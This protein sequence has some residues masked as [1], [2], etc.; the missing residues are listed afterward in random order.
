MHSHLGMY[1]IHL[2]VMKRLVYLL[3]GICALMVGIGCSDDE[4]SN[5][6]NAVI[7]GVDLEGT[8]SHEVTIYDNIDNGQ[9]ALYDFNEDGIEQ[10]VLL[11]GTEDINCTITFNE[12]NLLESLSLDSTVFVFSN[13]REG[14]VDMVYMCGEQIEIR[15]D[16]ELNMTIQEKVNTRSLRSEG[17]LEFFESADEYLREKQ[18]LFEIFS[19]A[20]DFVTDY[21]MMFNGKTGVEKLVGMIGHQKHVVDAMLIA[22][23]SDNPYIS[24]VSDAAFNVFKDIMKVKTASYLGSWGR[25]LYLLGNYTDYSNWCEA[26]WL[27]I[28]EWWDQYNT[29]AQVNMGKGILETG[30]GQ[31]KATLSWGFYAD[32]DLHAVEPSGEHLYFRNKYSLSTDGYL[33]RDNRNGGTNATENIYWENPPAGIYTFFIDY[34]GRSLS[35]NKQETGRCL[36]FLGYKDIKKV[37]SFD[38]NVDETSR[39]I[40][41]RLPEGI[42]EEGGT[43]RQA[44]MIDRAPK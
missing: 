16:L 27:K 9:I 42:I 29:T 12:N 32:I 44:I 13:Y 33:D 26:T 18:P 20:V 37:F 1:A 22:T 43:L 4:D 38:L 3:L 31:L 14:L 7:V 24:A 21:V 28:F 40:H 6:T 30:Q 36:L 8:S 19:L 39:M 34:Y 5:N 15:E 41:I 10:I 35:T 25:L 11:D 23:D 17:A 2:S